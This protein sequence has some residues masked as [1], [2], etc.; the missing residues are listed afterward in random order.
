MNHLIKEGQLPW[1]LNNYNCDLDVTGVTAIKTSDNNYEVYL[2]NSLYNKNV[3]SIFSYTFNRSLCEFGSAPSY[4]SYSLL[5]ISKNYQ[6]MTTCGN[7]IVA[8]T[9]FECIE[10]GDTN[11]L[12]W[13]KNNKEPQILHID[14]CSCGCSSK[15]IRDELLNIIVENTCDCSH[16]ITTTYMKLEGIT[17]IESSNIMLFGIS[18]IGDHSY[19]KNTSIII[20]A[21]YIVKDGKLF[22]DRDFKLAANFNLDT[23]A[24]CNC[25]DDPCLSLSDLCY[26]KNT[27]RI[28]VLSSNDNG[29]YLWHTGWYERLN[30]IGYSLK[31]FKHNGNIHKFQNPPKG[32]TC[33]NDGTIIV[34]ENHPPNCTCCSS[35]ELK[36]T[37]IKKY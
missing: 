3:S 9:S 1:V 32:L 10:N 7:F 30:R 27:K 12:F 18:I 20:R 6:S 29:G 14:D 24:K 25:I 33:L 21:P 16:D 22:I 2:L 28:Y 15:C 13:N 4:Y 37:I 34:V 36:Y 23:V 5:E 26:D 19:K 17:C 11:I 35:N 31:P 8:A